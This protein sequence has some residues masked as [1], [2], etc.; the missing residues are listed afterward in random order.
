MKQNQ[1]NEEQQKIKTICD[2]LF[3]D[4]Y[5]DN[6]SFLRFEKCFQPLFNNINISFEKVFNDICE[7]NKK[8]IT[9]KRFAKAYLNYKNKENISKDTIIFFDKL[10][11]SIFKKE[12]DFIGEVKE[13]IYSFSTKKTS[14]KRNYITILQVLSGYDE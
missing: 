1:N 2:F 11:N 13:K 8:Y 6:A 3:F 10:F 12:K 7:A 9:Y 4:Q 14:S 5:Q